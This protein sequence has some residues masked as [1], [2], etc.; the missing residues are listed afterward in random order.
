MF[1]CILWRKRFQLINNET[2]VQSVCLM[3]IPKII[4]KEQFYN[5]FHYNSFLSLTEAAWKV[6]SM[7]FILDMARYNESMFNT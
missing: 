7:N 5:K 3:F 4:I 1:N 2:S 6:F